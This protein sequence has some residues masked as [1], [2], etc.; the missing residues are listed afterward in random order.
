[1]ELV[2]YMM[3]HYQFLCHNILVYLLHFELQK[4]SLELS[5]QEKFRIMRKKNQ[6]KAKPSLNVSMNSNPLQQ[7]YYQQKPYPIQSKEEE[8][9]RLLLDQFSKPQR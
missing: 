1:M 7:P 5:I 2:N 9:V 6:E 3:H 8:I 4:Q